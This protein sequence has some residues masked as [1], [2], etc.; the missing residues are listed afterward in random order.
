MVKDANSPVE[1]KPVLQYNS[2]SPL[3]DQQNKIAFSSAELRNS[4]LSSSSSAFLKS[5]NGDSETAMPSSNLKESLHP[6]AYSV[7]GEY[8]ENFAIGAN[9]I[10]AV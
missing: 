5:L 8:D 1:F 10:T 4:F 3:V 7:E 6:S 9:Y 2:C